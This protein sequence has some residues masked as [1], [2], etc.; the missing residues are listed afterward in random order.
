MK[1]KIQKDFPYFHGGHNRR[2]YVAGE[3]IEADDQEFIDVSLREGWAVSETKS[4]DEAEEPTEEKARKRA[5]E[6]KAKG[7][8]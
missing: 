4:E 7:S 1:L 6:N 8:K 2:D 3:E 5:P